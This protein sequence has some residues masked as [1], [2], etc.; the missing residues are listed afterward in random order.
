MNATSIHT[1][2]PLRRLFALGLL[3]LALASGMARATPRL[4]DRI[5]A[6]V[7]DDVI[8]QSE[9]DDRVREIR[10]RLEQRKTRLP[11]LP[12][13]RR[14]VLDRLVLERL[15]LQLADHN[16]IDVSDETL[17]ATLRNLAAQN[18]MTL[19]QFRDALERQGQSYPAFRREIRREIRLRRLHQQ[20]VGNRIDVTDQEIDQFLASHDSDFDRREYHLAHILIPVPEAASPEQIEAAK[21]KAT[22]IL[23]QLRKGADFA[24]TAVAE[25][26]GRKALEGGD[27]GWLKGRRLP[28]LF[29]QAVRTMKPGDISDLIR[30]PSG[31][32]IIQLLGVRGGER[33]LV[34]Q[35]HV[36]HILLKPDALQD[37]QRVRL[38]LQQLRQR[39]LAGD[40]FATLAKAHS[41]DKVSAAKGGDL[42]W[43][44]PGD[45]VPAFEQA[46][47]RLKPGEIS[48]PVHTRF[49]WHII[50]VLARRQHDS[51]RDFKRSQAREILRKR[52][53][54]NELELWLRRLRD[55]AYVEYRLEDKD[56]PGA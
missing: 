11:P 53:F 47:A 24:H 22:R 42:G 56:A 15:Q 14:Q 40:D 54:E 12:Q 4:L 29:A 55:E 52:K 48:P 26:A 17:N 7:N 44:G 2:S 32:H 33:H 19:E 23:S 5:V 8:L 1:A 9:L 21:K 25:S 20:M 34:T 46:M 18:G 28:S 16:H 39:I 43:V 30:S 49:G 3:A 13:L 6:V 50:Q 27:L 37:S 31:F 51:T 41:E 38:R 35:T 10:Q 36:R 45:L